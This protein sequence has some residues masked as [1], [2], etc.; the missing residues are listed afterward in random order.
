MQLHRLL[1]P[2][3]VAVIGVSRHGQGWGS[4]V[5]ASMIDRGYAG[6]LY[7]VNPAFPTESAGHVQT[8]RSVRD[9]GEPVDCAI[10]AVGR[11]HVP[12]LVEEC[13]AAGVGA[14][15]LV[16]SGFGELGSAG[17]EREAAILRAGAASGM[18]I[19][20]PN[21]FG[22]FCAEPRLNLTTRSDI[23]AG[24]VALAS[25]SGNIAIELWEM[26]KRRGIGFSYC[27][28]VGNQMDVGFPELISHFAA[29]A[30][31]RAIALY[32]EGV[33]QGQGMAFVAALRACQDADKTVV[34][35]RAGRTGDGAVAA[36]TH[37]AALA[38]DDRVWSA[39]LTERGA[40]MAS[41]T[42]DVTDT[43]LA[44]TRVPRHWGRIAVLTDGGG[45]S[46]LAVDSIDQHQ[47]S[48]A[49]YDA[50]T[51]QAVATKIPETAPRMPGLNP[52]VLDTAGGMDDDPSLLG[53]CARIVAG[54]SGVDVIVIAGIL[55]GYSALADKQSESVATLIELHRSGRPVVVQ[56]AYPESAACLD[57]QAAGMA[58]YP[59]V[60]RMIRSIAHRRLGE[61][62]PTAK[63]SE[64]IAH[65]VGFPELLQLLRT[66]GIAL[67]DWY[68]V[69]DWADLDR[70]ELL[71]PT[72][73]CVK[74]ADAGITHKS[75]VGGVRLNLVDRDQVRS[76]AADLWGVHQ[77]SPLL[78]MPMLEPGFEALVGSFTD[79][80]FGR[81]LMIGRGGIWTEVEQDVIVVPVADGLSPRQLRTRLEDL[82]CYPMLE[83]AR[84]QAK[85]DVE[86]L[87]EFGL[88]LAGVVEDDQN[89][90]I[91]ANPVFVYQRGCALADIRAE[92]R[93]PSD[94]VDR[95]LE[96]GHRTSA[97]PVR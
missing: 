51:R 60:E 25:Q 30:R 34:V 73:A 85:L 66:H 96:L 11:D 91:E 31:T 35:L 49:E 15:V 8:A 2:A 54:D 33:P 97:E 63:A 94:D 12:D 40:L 20:G 69:A 76:A 78:V 79:P 18:R 22:L 38:G 14:V 10:L 16:A 24:D 17:H 23:P 62:K 82:R 77:L 72:P 53:Q 29:D 58:L 6:R 70:Q 80:I 27:V 71:L 41:S 81:M 93:T 90:V 39:I 74:L 1:N 89:L 43:V 65:P 5:L 7:S 21:C 67:S 50:S 55:G 45:C 84:G 32:L 56:S 75:D 28:G 83:G 68:L 44:A 46:V 57:L 26:A 92:W 87:C 3:S 9:I 48:L 47:L 42:E 64:A 59:T 52:T 88:R 36:R 61:Q 95:K 19:L 4:R 13:A 37:T 86:S